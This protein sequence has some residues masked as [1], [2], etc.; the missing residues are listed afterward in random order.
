MQQQP[1]DAGGSVA[2][3]GYGGWWSYEHTGT[4]G[5]FAIENCTEKLLYW[6]PQQQNGALPTMAQEANAD[7]RPC[8]RVTENF[9]QAV[10]STKAM[11]T[12]KPKFRI[13]SMAA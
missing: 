12:I 1:D 6:N 11:P 4:K 13:R 9:I 3:F 8:R 5:T 10:S 7:Q 2:A